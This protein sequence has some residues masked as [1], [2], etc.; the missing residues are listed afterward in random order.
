MA[1]D[2]GYHRRFQALVQSDFAL[3]AVARFQ[4]PIATA[5]QAFAK[6]SNLRECSDT[7]AASPRKSRPN[8]PSHPRSATGTSNSSKKEHTKQCKPWILV[9]FFLFLEHSRGGDVEPIKLSLLENA[10]SFVTESLA[11]VLAAENDPQ[12]WKFAILAAVQAIE[13]ILKELLRREHWTLLFQ[14]IDKPKLTVSLDQAMERLKNVS[15]VRISPDEVATIRTAIALRNRVVHADVSFEPDQVKAIVAGLI[16]FASHLFATFLHKQLRE[17]VNP[18]IWNQAIQ[19][20]QFSHHLWT[21]ARDRISRE[22]I[23]DDFLIDCSCC[24]GDGVLV[25]KEQTKI[26][27]CYVCGHSEPIDRCRVCGHAIIELDAGWIAEQPDLPVCND[28]E[29]D[30][31]RMNSWYDRNREM[32]SKLLAQRGWQGH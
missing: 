15:P 4:N 24:E 29:C 11:K 16:Q 32:L 14:N 10:E 25:A 2:T 30:A 1:D 26:A 22:G 9:V 6:F 23:T 20:G 28:C 13:L 8:S 27:T 7:S 19:L 31:D 12:Q 5:F 18:E 17:A 3:S 21:L